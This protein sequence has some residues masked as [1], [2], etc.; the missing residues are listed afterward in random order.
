M[1][2]PRRKTVLKS[3]IVL[4][5]IAAAV[6]SCIRQVEKTPLTI[7]ASETPEAIAVS[8]SGKAFAA[9]S[10]TIPEHK[11]FECA[12]CHRREGGNDDLKFAGH[13]SCVGCHISQF[14]NPE[15]Q[16]MCTICHAD[17][18]AVPPTMQEFPTRFV[19]GF[20]MKFDHAAH[21]SGKGRPPEGCVACHEAAGAA[22]TIPVGINA[23]TTCYTCH[24]PESNIGSCNVCHEVAPYRRTPTGRYV[25]KA[26]FSHREHSGAQGLNCADCHSV[27]GAGA[28]QGSQV[29]NILAQ[30]HT[31][32]GNNCASCHNGSRAFTGNDPTNMT[33]CARCHTGSGFN[34]LP[35]SPF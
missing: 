28:P 8:I 12:S 15:Q 25:F 31:R 2:N 27:R 9:F 30:Q 13:D 23:H 18:K 32:P 19:E 14:T 17:T 7:T 21:I 22:K 1:R 16:M 4:C 11:E 33:T 35:G 3:V 10:H 6:S 26:V 34:M 29:T 5:T 24:T 20:N